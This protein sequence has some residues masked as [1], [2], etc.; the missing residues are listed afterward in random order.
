MFTVG[1]RVRFTTNFLGGDEY[2][3]ME[4]KVVAVSNI[5]EFGLEPG[6]IPFPYHVIDCF[7][8]SS[9]YWPVNG[10]EIELVKEDE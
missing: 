5:I 4:T 6:A 8:P 7:D 3:G 9:P 2:I 1:D 10:D